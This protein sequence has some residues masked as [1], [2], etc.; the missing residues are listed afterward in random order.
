MPVVPVEFRKPTATELAALE[1]LI[2]A[3]PDQ[4]RAIHDA[5]GDPVVV[6]ECTCG[7]GC[8]T[9]RMDTARTP[10]SWR[11]EILSGIGDLRCVPLPGYLEADVDDG[12][13]HAY[14]HVARGAAEVEFWWIGRPDPDAGRPLFPQRDDWT[15]YWTPE[16]VDSTGAG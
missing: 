10:A 13:V 3:N 5:L 15:I 14:L 4:A 1:L 8:F 6:A 16:F 9:V 7:Q 2:D 12:L 11:T